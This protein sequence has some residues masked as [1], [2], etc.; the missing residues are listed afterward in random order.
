MTSHPVPARRTRRILAMLAI[1]ASFALFLS[2][3]DAQQQPRFEVTVGSNVYL[4]DSAEDDPFTIAGN[5]PNIEIGAASRQPPDPGLAS[6]S[7]RSPP[8]RSSRTSWPAS[9]GDR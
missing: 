7:T 5:G 9:S 6:A 3:A 4:G 1:L 8:A 2:P